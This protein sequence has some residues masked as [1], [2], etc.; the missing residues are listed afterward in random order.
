MAH[1]HLEY[2]TMIDTLRK[3]AIDDAEVQAKK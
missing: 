2:D 3:Q 1:A